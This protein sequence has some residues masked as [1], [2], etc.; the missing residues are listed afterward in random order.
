MK[1]VY[2]LLSYSGS[3]PSHLIHYYTRDPYAHASI[4]LDKELKEMY[5]FARLRPNNPLIAGFVHEDLETGTFNKFKNATCQLYTLNVTEKQYESLKAEIVKFKNQRDRY[6]Y[7]FLG[8]LTAMFNK[9]FEREFK[10]FCSQFVATVL[11][12]S[13]IKIVEKPPGL[14]KPMDFAESGHLKLIFEGRLHDY[15]KEL[16]KE[17][18]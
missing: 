6:G 4:S 8:V 9:P 7:N 3:V 16:Q 15:P 2:L 14:T 12:N 1:E 10:Y 5:S 17:N 13:D 11:H 18:I